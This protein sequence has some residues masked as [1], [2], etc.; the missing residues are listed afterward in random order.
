MDRIIDTRKG[1]SS[2]KTTVGAP[3]PA[4]T[5][6]S[7]PACSHSPPP[8]GTTGSS[9]HPSND[10]SPPATT[11]PIRTHSSNE[12]SPRTAELRAGQ[13]PVVRAVCGDDRRA[14]GERCA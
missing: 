1:H 5:P 13:V 6:E 2:S 4:S 14:D 12:A 11:E 7:P 3:W 9:T 10:P 8:S